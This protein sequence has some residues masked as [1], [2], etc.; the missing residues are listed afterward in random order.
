MFKH[1][2]ALV[3]LS[4]LTF[5]ANAALY[6][7]G[8]GMIYDSE[9]NITWLQD[10]NYAKTQHT[11]TNGSQGAANGLM[12]WTAARTWAANLSYGGYNNW[13]LPSANLINGANPCT[14]YNGS[15]DTGWNIK[16][17]ELGHMFFNNL[18]NLSSH[19][20][21]GFWQSGSGVMNRS[22]DDGGNGSNVS[23]SNLDNSIYWFDEEY[24]PDT[25]RA[26]TLFTSMGWQV[27]LGKSST[28]L[29]WAVRDGDVSPVPVPGAAWLLGT[30]LLGLA[31]M[32]RGYR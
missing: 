1:T 17:S 21:N 28:V 11:A 8:G 29:S 22:F 6:D 12:T 9:L 23:I 4:V 14:A 3:G 5:S 30:A 26:W 32:K 13:R 16:R 27:D 20:V 25:D 31:G 10:A 15:C 7:R 19:D 2:I 18:A 24:A